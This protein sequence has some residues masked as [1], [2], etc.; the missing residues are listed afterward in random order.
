MADCM[1]DP[2]AGVTAMERF[3][4]L[5]GGGLALSV[6]PGFDPVV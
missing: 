2:A 6:T 4:F 5:S 1:E 3:I